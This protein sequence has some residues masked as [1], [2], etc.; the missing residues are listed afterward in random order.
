MKAILNTPSGPSI[1]EVDDPRPG[2]AEALVAVRAFSINRGELALLETRTNDWRPGQDIAGVVVEPAADGAGPPAG[3]RVVA[4]VEQ[5]GWAELAAVPTTRLAPLP[6]EVTI[7]QAAAL[8]LAGLT[9]LRTLRLGGNLLGRRV[10]VTGAS[11]GLGGMQVQLALAAGAQ[12]T[13]VTRTQH[14]EQLLRLGTTSV[15]ADPADADG[16]Y[17]L[18]ADWVGGASLAAALGKVAPRGIVVLGSG[19]PDKTPINIY[20]FFGHE[21]A[22]LVSYLSYAHPEPPGPDLTILARL[23][24]TGRL[25]PVLGLLDAWTQLP[26]AIN[27]LTERRITGKAVLTVS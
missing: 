9:A 22:R 1:A 8:P 26:D 14:E 11:G 7:E 13:A 27:A 5:A 4:L 21:G 20:D 17:D 15:V 16:L 18:V 10:L 24:A 3:T 25:D 12:V 19:N 2:G 6:D 23:V